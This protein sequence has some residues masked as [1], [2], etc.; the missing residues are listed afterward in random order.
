MTREFTPAELEAY[1]DEALTPPEMA[2]VEAQL[3]Q[4]PELTRRLQSILGRRDAGVHCLA[5][6]W[7]RHRISCAD[8][9]TLGNYL[10]GVLPEEQAKYVRFHIEQIGCRICEANL[11]DLRRRQQ[12]LSDAASR[13]QRYF[14][15]SAGL[16]R[17]G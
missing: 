8:R 9:E 14:Q 6:I 12:Q 7:R 13:Q 4:R 17:K 10:L 11:D 15:S 5:E 3:R 2:E 1:L 16:L